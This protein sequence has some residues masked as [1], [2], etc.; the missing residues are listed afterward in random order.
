M[1]VFTF[2]A[3]EDIWEFTVGPGLCRVPTGCQAQCPT[4]C[5]SWLYP[6]GSWGSGDECCLVG[7]GTEVQGVECPVEVLTT[8]LSPAFPTCPA[9]WQFQPWR[10]PDIAA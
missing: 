10:A 7:L 6:Q 4:P 3:P 5:C 8:K 2:Q 1:P 9:I